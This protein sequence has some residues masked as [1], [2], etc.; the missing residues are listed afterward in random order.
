[1]P[2]KKR[3]VMVIFP[4]ETGAAVAD[5]AKAAGQSQSRIVSELMTEMTPQLRDLAKL[6][7]AARSG[8]KEAAKGALRDLVGGAMAAIIEE[9]QPDLFERI[10][11]RKAAGS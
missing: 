6:L 5:L 11:K 1:M 2:T 7:R 4:D 9:L 3:R 8:G 10:E